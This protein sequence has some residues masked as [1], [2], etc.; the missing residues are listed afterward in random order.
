[1]ELR[2]LRLNESLLGIATVLLIS[3]LGVCVYGKDIQVEKWD[4]FELELKGPSEGN[5]YI[6]IELS[7]VFKKDDR[8]IKVAGFYDGQGRYI[9][10]FSPD[11]KG[12]WTYQTQSNAAELSDKTGHLSCTAPT[13]DN[14]G[15]VRIVNTYYLQYA[16]GTPYYAVGTTCYQ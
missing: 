2:N 9:I 3:A 15:P 12:E 5:P 4:I 10:R 13:D 11:E 14:H 6:D 8:E 7:A 16:D 1:M